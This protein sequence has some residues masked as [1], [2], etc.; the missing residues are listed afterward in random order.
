MRKI[1]FTLFATAA[2]FVGCNNAAPKAELKSDADTLSYAVGVS[3]AEGIEQFLA[4]AGVDSTCNDQFIKG[5]IDGMNSVDDKQLYA[6]YTGIAISNQLYN[7]VVRGAN[8]SFAGDDSTK[9]I[10]TRNLLAG[11]IDGL[12]KK[13]KM[14]REEAFDHQNKIGNELQQKMTAKKY[15]GNK[16]AGEEYL[17]KNK[18]AKDVVT[19][20]S[21]VQ[22]KV[23]EEGRGPIPA[24]NSVITLHYVGKLIDGTEFDS[25]RERGEAMTIQAN[26]F[27]PG[28]TEALTHMPVGSK[29]VVTIPQEQAYGD[30]S[31]GN[32]PPYSVLIFDVEL[33]S[34][35]E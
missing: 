27:I 21:G 18:A 26:Q 14:T 19:L 31:A 35:N 4:Y 11:L 24:D 22:Y 3:N 23:I 13:N 9:V 28:F 5:L 8:R 29:W 34:I 7:N 17:A 32:I 2:V 1:L 20:P 12:K 25:T 16:Q 10:S 30:K 6:Y 33:I 15:A